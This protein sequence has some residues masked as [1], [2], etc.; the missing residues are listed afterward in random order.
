MGNVVLGQKTGRC[1]IAHSMKFSMYN[2][3]EEKNYDVLQ[4]WITFISLL[5]ST[6]DFHENDYQELMLWY[7][8]V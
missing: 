7:K 4:F 2:T 3:L 8:Y 1:L 6:Q 5:R